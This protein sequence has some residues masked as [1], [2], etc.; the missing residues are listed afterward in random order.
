M[1]FEMDASVVETPSDVLA[2]IQ[3]SLRSG[4]QT[5]EDL[6]YEQTLLLRQDIETHG[7]VPTYY[8]GLAYGKLLKLFRVSI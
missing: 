3:D 8:A 6:S 1:D 4:V 5:F 7:S 2:F